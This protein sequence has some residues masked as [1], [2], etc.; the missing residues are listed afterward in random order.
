MS[1]NLRQ[2]G[3]QNETVFYQIYPLGFCGAPL[4]NDGQ[5][6]NR[7]AKVKDWLPHLVKLGVGAVY[8]CPVFDSDRHGYDTHRPPPGLQP[9]LQRNLPGPAQCRHPGG[10][11]RRV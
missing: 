4:E 8:F 11:G 2:P 5:T 6:V 3:W 9:G 1:Q 10:A 7:I